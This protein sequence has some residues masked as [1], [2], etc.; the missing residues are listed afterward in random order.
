MCQASI[1]DTTYSK[2]THPFILCLISTIVMISTKVAKPATH[3][4]M[5][6]TIGTAGALLEAEVITPL[7]MIDVIELV[8]MIKEVDMGEG[9]CTGEQTPHPL[10][11]YPEQLM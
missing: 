8:L 5:I 10:K 7:D 1:L 11:P 9:M 6:A 2:V 4:S 3:G